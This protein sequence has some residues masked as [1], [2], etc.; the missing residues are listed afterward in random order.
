MQKNHG[1]YIYI[2][3]IS[4]LKNIIELK[5]SFYQII[6]SWNANNHV[7]FLFILLLW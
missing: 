4:Y 3:I 1:L 7:G 5:N 2:Y 6:P